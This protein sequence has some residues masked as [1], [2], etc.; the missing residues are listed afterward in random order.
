M[1]R[2]YGAQRFKPSYPLVP[3]GKPGSA[4]LFST[5]PREKRIGTILVGTIV[6]IQDGVRPLSGFTRPIVCREPWIVE[7]WLN[8][9][10]SKWDAATQSFRTVWVSGGHL[11]KVRSLRDS[12]RVQQVADWI[13]LK[14]IDA[15]L[16][17]PP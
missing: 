10:H 17:K 13:L 16:E 14:C 12:R 5:D 11:A 6:Y 8:R 9:E 1:I 15:G 4:Q 2:Q 7:A 3:N